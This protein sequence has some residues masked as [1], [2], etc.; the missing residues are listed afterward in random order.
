MLAMRIDK[1]YMQNVQNISEHLQ[2]LW[3]RKERAPAENIA[4]RYSMGELDPQKTWKEGHTHSRGNGSESLSS[5]QGSVCTSSVLW[6][7][8]R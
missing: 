2:R 5:E 6:P 3:T 8:R 4:I 7:T 1:T